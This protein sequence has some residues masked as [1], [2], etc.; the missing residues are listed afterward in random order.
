M[1]VQNL[2]LKDVQ[3]AD[4]IERYN[5]KNYINW[6]RSLELALE[7]LGAF[8]MDPSTEF[9][10][11]VEGPRREAIKS[12]PSEEES[13]STKMTATR[14]VS[15]EDDK[16]GSKVESSRGAAPDVSS[17]SAS[18]KKTLRYS[19]GSIPQTGL[20]VRMEDVDEN[21]DISSEVIMITAQTNASLLFL[22]RMSVETRYKAMIKDKNCRAAYIKLLESLRPKTSGMV[23]VLRERLE[24]ETFKSGTILDHVTRLEQLRDEYMAAGGAEL[25]DTYFSQIIVSS[26][27]ANSIFSSYLDYLSYQPQLPDPESLDLGTFR[28]QNAATISQTIDESTICAFLRSLLKS[29]HFFAG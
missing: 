18:A 13:M 11:K 4:A 29:A 16:S 17:A 1:A 10:V 7:S 3:H 21:A 8:Y 6:S 25:S 28:R 24:H 22:L 5:G 12:F 9:I 20:R 14:E 27:P 26:I 15:D 2:R 23:S 19:T